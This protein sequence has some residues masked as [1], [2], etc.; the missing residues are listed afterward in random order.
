MAFVTAFYFS[1]LLLTVSNP[2]SASSKECDFPAIFNFGD[3]ISDTGG[4]SAMYTPV[5]WPYGISY[6]HM[7]A[8]RYSDG[9]LPIDLMANSLGLPFLHAYIDSIRANFSHGANF[10]TSA[11]TIRAQNATFFQE[12]WSPFSLDVQIWQYNQ[13]KSR[14]QL[15][16]NQE[17]VFKKLLPKE[18]YFS[19]ALYT[20]DIGS[21]DLTAA[22]YINM[23]R[24]NVSYALT[25]MLN[26]YTTAIKDVYEN[27]GRSF[28]IHNIGP[29]GCHA[30][31]LDAIPLPDDQLD[32][33][34]CAIP[35]NNVMMD[36]NRRLKAIVVQ[37]RKDLPLA[38][39]TY[40]D[41][42]T[43]KYTLFSQYK[44]LGFEHNIRACCGRG[45]KYNYSRLSRCGTTTVVNG[46]ESTVGPCKDPSAYV[47]WDGI[48]HTQAANEWVFKQIV[49][50]KYSDPPIP[51][52]MACNKQA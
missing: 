12:G 27:G 38:S 52:R 2:T 17:G 35:W 46:T 1:I 14:S 47:L 5:P 34:G 45:G 31:I 4:L 16:Y 39:F 36:F 33:A 21:N 3:S 9:R 15:A 37:L 51:L 43:V 32:K 22:N 40:V 6:F 13:F 30:Y 23:S 18:D 10:A 28:W 29:L 20:F 11:S 26:Q 48:H 42:Y 19:R 49:D 7:P 44:K 25:D 50:G 8:G 24:E 41:M